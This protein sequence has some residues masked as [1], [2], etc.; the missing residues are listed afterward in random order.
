[1]QPAEMHFFVVSTHKEAPKTA[2]TVLEVS[3]ICFCFIA[4]PRRGLVRHE[5]GCYMANVKR[6]TKQHPVETV[7][8]KA[9]Q[10]LVLFWFLL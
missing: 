9:A 7:E 3:F 4:S 6:K 10:Y 8:F 1:M 2:L 5:F